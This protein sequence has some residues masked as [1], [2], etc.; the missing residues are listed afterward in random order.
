MGCRSYV[1]I[2]SRGRQ[3]PNTV[4][5]HIKKAKRLKPVQEM[6]PHEA[7]YWI[8]ELVYVVAMSDMRHPI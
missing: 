6:R 2:L 4:A 8:C 3:S 1:L 5:K 7:Q